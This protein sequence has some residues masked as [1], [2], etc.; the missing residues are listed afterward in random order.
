M[1]KNW[2][3]RAS[4]KHKDIACTYIYTIPIFHVSRTPRT[5]TLLHVILEYRVP[6]P[7]PISDAITCCRVHSYAPFIIPFFLASSTQR[8]SFRED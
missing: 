4:G 1:A 7:A 3:P 5:A 6:F 8:P 2:I